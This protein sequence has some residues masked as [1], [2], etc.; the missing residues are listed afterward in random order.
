MKFL[1]NGAEIDDKDI[2]EQ[3]KLSFKQ[4]VEKALEED[5]GV[6]NDKEDVWVKVD[7]VQYTVKVYDVLGHDET[8]PFEASYTLEDDLENSA[9][10]DLYMQYLKSEGVA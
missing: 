8:E 2:M 6:Q 9:W 3:G 4:F 1:V 10:D 5:G 7:G